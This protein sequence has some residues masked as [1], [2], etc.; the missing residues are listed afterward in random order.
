MDEAFRYIVIGEFKYVL[1]NEGRLEI[2][3]GHYL[4]GSVFEEN[5]L[6]SSEQEGL[7]HLEDKLVCT[8]DVDSLNDFQPRE[9]APFTPSPIVSTDGIPIFTSKACFCFKLFKDVGEAYEFENKLIFRGNIFT[10]G[11]TFKFIQEENDIYIRSMEEN[12]D[13]FLCYNDNNIRFTEEMPK[14]NN[15]QLVPGKYA[16]LFYMYDGRYYYVVRFY[17]ASYGEVIRVNS[18]DEATI[19]QVISL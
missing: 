8:V 2:H 18:K 16:G 3:D 17:T 14:N 6:E 5:H 10:Q 1:L 15:I 12:D 13:R 19:F 9:L 7:F 4:H 11:M